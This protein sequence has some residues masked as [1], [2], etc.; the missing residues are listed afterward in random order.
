MTVLSLQAFL[1][2]KLLAIQTLLPAA[3][4][5]F[6]T[7]DVEIFA[8]EDFY[9]FLHYIFQEREHIAFTRTHHQVFYPPNDTWSHFF[10]GTRKVR[11]SCDS[12]QFVTWSF[13]F[14]NYGDETFSC[15]SYNVLGFFLSVETAV[16]STFTFDTCSAHFCQFRIFLDFDTPT[17]VFSQMP[18]HTVDFQHCH[19]VELTLH[20]FHG[21]E[22]TTRVKVNTTI[23]ETWSI[24]YGY[25]RKCPIC[26]HNTLAFH[27]GRQKLE[28]SLHTIKCTGTSLGCNFD[29]AWSHH[30][31]V[32]FG[33]H[34]E[35]RIHIQHDVTFSFADG[36]VETSRCFQLV[37]KEFSHAL[38]FQS[39]S[40][41]SCA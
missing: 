20:F 7:T 12:C 26:L 22:V 3:L 6:V 13:E 8:R 11:I 21:L 2:D 36:E 33:I 39:G 5:T 10:T 1:T 40:L 30:E 25:T 34:F 24:F 37:H 32:T 4:R 41:E 9:H 35:S 15:V 31:F 18:M 38:C 16:G 28:N 29:V 23:S 14:R 17:L 27:F 19:Y